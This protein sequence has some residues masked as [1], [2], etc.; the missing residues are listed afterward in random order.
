M[1]DRYWVGGTGSWNTSSTAHWSATS[2]GSSG[3]SAPG[4]GDNAIFDANSASGD[5]TV[6][7]TTTA[8][9]V[10]NLTL[11]NPT[12]GVLT[13]AGATSFSV[14]GNLTVSA[15]VLWTHAGSMIFKATD[16]GH[17]ITTNGVSV[18]SSMTFNGAGG[19]WTLQDALTVVDASGIA[20]TQGSFNSNGV[21]ISAVLFDITGTATRSITLGSSVL[22]LSGAGT[23][24]SISS[25]TGLT[26]S[27]ASSTIKATNNSSS[28]KSFDG[29][30]NTF[31][32][33][34]WANQGTGEARISGS[35]TFSTLRFDN[36]GNA[37]KFAASSN[38]TVTTAT[39]SGT[40]GNLVTL[41]TT[42]G[43]GTFTLT[44]AGGGIVS[45]DYLSVT[46]S[47]A[48]PS[49]TW[50]A[51]THSTDGGNNS[52]WT[53]T[54]APSASGPAGVK[55]WNGLAAASVKTVDGLAI[56]SVKTRDG[57]A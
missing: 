8:P 2:G 1:A 17:T 49:S 11:A 15:G 50:Y 27:A 34:W 20:V 56:A 5:Y 39:I 21:A 38:T 14:Y 53:F 9:S 57:L 45:L 25:N 48:T 33:L 52:G 10:A 55:T 31:G 12:G 6:T 18:G 37:L 13:L 41:D 43:S 47:A 3:A 19:G 42:S 22:T 16:T 28:S 29:N 30:G 36:V 54:D 35:N 26:L 46:R 32:T 24:F 23:V 4:S 51:G 7:P 40:A 44:K